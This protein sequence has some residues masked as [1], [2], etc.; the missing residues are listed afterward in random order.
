MQQLV[1][2]DGNAQ[3]SQAL[4]NLGSG[5]FGEEEEV[6]LGIAVVAHEGHLVHHVG[7]GSMGYSMLYSAYE[8]TMSSPLYGGSLLLATLQEAQEKPIASLYVL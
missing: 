6:A 2:C 4:Q 1:L 8:E 7:H 5:E 3:F